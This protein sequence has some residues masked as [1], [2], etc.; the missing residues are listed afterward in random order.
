MSSSSFHQDW[1]PIVFKKHEKKKGPS[2][3]SRAQKLDENK[4]AFD[5]H[6][7]IQKGLADA[8]KNARIQLKIT[9]DQ[10]AKQVNVRPNVINDIEAQRGIYDHIAVNKIKKILGI[11]YK[12]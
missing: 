9:Q 12:Q 1:E 6:K 10:L 8:I 3:P 4:E 5:D 11:K 7:K 2:G